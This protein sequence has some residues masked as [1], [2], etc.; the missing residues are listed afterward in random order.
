MLARGALSCVILSVAR[1]SL[2]IAGG[3]PPWPV[4]GRGGFSPEAVS[5]GMFALL[6]HN[7]MKITRRFTMK[8]LLPHFVYASLSGLTLMLL[9]ATAAVANT[10][11]YSLVPVTSPDLNVSGNTDTLSGTIVVSSSGNIYGN[12]SSSNTASYP[13]SFTANWTMSSA[14]STAI[15]PISV[16]ETFDIDTMINNGWLQRDGITIGPSNISLLNLS[17]SVPS[18]SGYFVADLEPVSTYIEATWDPYDGSQG[19]VEAFAGVSPAPATMFFENTNANAS[20]FVPVPSPW[21]VATAVPEPTSL[22]LAL[23]V[24]LLAL[25]RRF[26][27]AGAR[28]AN[29]YGKKNE[30]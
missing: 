8:K 6:S 18:Q 19:V 29:C 22:A 11:T 14:G 16:S 4:G 30:A 2:A 12:Y 13:I 10:A 25:G 21:I 23:A 17:D 24:G 15:T 3:N 9:A 28:F 20:P 5:G 1:S 27:G 26:Y 7:L